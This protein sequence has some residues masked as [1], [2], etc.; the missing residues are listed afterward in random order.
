MLQGRLEDHTDTLFLSS[1][2]QVP[3]I[4][5]RWSGMA[6]GLEPTEPSLRA[7]VD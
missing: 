2:K 5:G 3:G 4:K 6:A 7:L 1:N